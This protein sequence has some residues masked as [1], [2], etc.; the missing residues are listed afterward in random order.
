MFEKNRA[1]SY[2]LLLRIL[3]NSHITTFNIFFNWKKS[4]QAG[5]RT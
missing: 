3:L 4:V 1:D 5:G 2:K